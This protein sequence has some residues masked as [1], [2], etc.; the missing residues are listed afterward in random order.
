M[1][2]SIWEKELP[3][4]F[5]ESLTKISDLSLMQSFLRDV[6]TEK[7]ITELSARFEAAKMLSR[8]EKY[9]VI[10]KKT[11]LSSRTVARISEWLKNGNGGYKQAIELALEHHAHIPPARA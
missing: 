2:N 11:S 7:E 10:I 1:K 8:G 3:L 9:T 4:K 6:M 5:S